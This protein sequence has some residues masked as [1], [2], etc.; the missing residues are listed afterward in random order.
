MKKILMVVVIGILLISCDNSEKYDQ[1]EGEWFCSDWIIEATGENR[2]RNNVYFNFNKDKTYTS[3]IDGL[4]ETG[5]YLIANGHLYSTPKGK[6][7]IGVELNKFNKDT[8]QFIMSR[9]GAKETL[10]L[11]K[12]K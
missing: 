8:L 12:K 4:E 2:C 6:L 7:E 5:T 11:I 9:A 10:T 3:K 1:I